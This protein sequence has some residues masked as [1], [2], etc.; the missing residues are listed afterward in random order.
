M[1]NAEPPEIFGK[2]GRFVRRRLEGVDEFQLELES[3]IA[4]GSRA[5]RDKFRRN[6]P[7]EGEWRRVR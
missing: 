3:R 4:N 1:F 7:E 6:K 2:I 5:L